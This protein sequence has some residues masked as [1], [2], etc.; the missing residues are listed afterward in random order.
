MVAGHKRAQKTLEMMQQEAYW[1]CMAQ[2][3]EHSVE[4]AHR[5]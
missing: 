2:V 5:K 4:S 1:A 3:L